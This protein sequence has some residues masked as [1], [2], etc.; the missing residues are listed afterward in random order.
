MYPLLSLLINNPRKG[1]ARR[2]GTGA[3]LHCGISPREPQPLERCP[4]HDHSSTE[5]GSPSA[6]LLFRTSAMSRHFRRTLGSLG[7]DVGRPDY[8]SPLPGIVDQEFP[9]VGWRQ[10]HRDVPEAGDAFPNFGV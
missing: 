7:F 10:R 3:P 4:L 5:S 1:L 6:G 9:E 2:A 8:L